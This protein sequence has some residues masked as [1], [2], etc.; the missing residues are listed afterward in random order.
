[1]I[2]CLIDFTAVAL[3]RACTSPWLWLGTL[4]G[5]DQFNYSVLVTHK[6]TNPSAGLLR[7]LGCAGQGTEI[8]IFGFN[9]SA[10]HYFTHQMASEELIV[11]QLAKGFNITV[12]ATACDGLR[13]C[14]A[15]CDGAEYQFAKEGEG[16]DCRKKCG[17]PPPQ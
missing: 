15:L 1:M 10:K 14:E 16:A 4:S 2:D 3:N 12:H 7:I 9:W 5:V 11:R 13:S 8:H 6:V 17:S